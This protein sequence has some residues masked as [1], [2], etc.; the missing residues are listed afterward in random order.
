MRSSRTVSRGWRVPSIV[1]CGNLRLVPQLRLIA[2]AA[3]LPL[4]ACEHGIDLQGQ[5]SVPAQ[6]QQMFSA[7]HPGELVVTAQI[8]GLPDITA[9]SVILCAPAASERVIDVK[10]LKVA[11]ASEDT[12]LISAWV[13]P[14]TAN[15]V[16]CTAA[17]PHPRSAD[18]PQSS[19]AVALAR[20]VVPV[21]IAAMDPAACKDGSISFAVTLVPR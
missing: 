15:E 6:V 3:A 11:C 21:R 10:V 1:P 2:L 9:P 17:P 5:V 4:A 20:A 8:P 16:S 13:V 7:Q 12:A 18:A 14:R 19:D